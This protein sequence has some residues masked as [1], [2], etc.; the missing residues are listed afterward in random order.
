MMSVSDTRSEAR[1]QQQ[2]DEQRRD[3]QQQPDDR[4]HD[5][6]D[7]AAAV[8][9]QRAREPA[10]EECEGD[11]SDRHDDDAD[12]TGKEAAPD[13]TPSRRCPANGARNGP[14]RRNADA[15]LGGREAGASAGPTSSTRMAAA[16]VKPMSALRPPREKRQRVPAGRWSGALVRHQRNT[17]RRRRGL[18]TITETIR[19][20]IDEDEADGRDHHAGLDNGVVYGGDREHGELSEA[21]EAEH[22]LD[23]GDARENFS[24]AQGDHVDHRAQRVL[25]STWRASSCGVG[26]PRAMAA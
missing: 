6:V 2:G 24:K 14:R 5:P 11:G 1:D 4:G 16:I 23:D 7:R 8:G 20:E 25:G 3:R 21:G 18:A 13:V 22:R 19:G 26:T 15:D 17:S 10:D 12:A 9:G